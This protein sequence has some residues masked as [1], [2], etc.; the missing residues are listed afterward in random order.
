MWTPPDDSLPLDSRLSPVQAGA[1]R[2][3]SLGGLTAGFTGACVTCG[4]C[5]CCA[6]SWLGLLGCA[7]TQAL[8][9]AWR[10]QR[11]SGAKLSWPPSTVRFT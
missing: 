1:L 3:K 8:T 6:G 5:T 11:V 7:V 10:P 2:V 4:V 9:Q